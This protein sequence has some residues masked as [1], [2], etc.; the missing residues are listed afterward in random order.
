[1]PTH[2]VYKILHR[3]IRG[4]HEAAYLLAFFTLGSQLMALVRDRLLAHKFG[5]G[6]VLDVFY[7]AFRIPDTMYAILASMVS[8]FVLIPFLERARRD[9]TDAIQRFLSDMFSFFSGALVLF[10]LIVFV[11]TPELIAVLYGGFSASMQADLVP[12]VRI[13]L[14]Q[15][16]LLGISNLFAAYVQVQG[17]FLLYA[18][19]PIVYNLGIIAG[20]VFLEP[21]IGIQGLAWGVVFGALLHLLIQAPFVAHQGVFP[22]LVWPEW[23]RVYDVVR[24]SIP[25]TLTLSAQQLVILVL[26]SIAALF[27]VGSVSSFSLA[28]NLQ[29]VPLAIIGA[30]YSVAAFPKLA[31]LFGNGDHVEYRALILTAARQILFWAFPATILVIILRAQLVRVIFGTGA[32]D[33]DD[34][35]LVGAMLALL[36]VSLVAQSLVVLLVRACYAAGQTTVPLI[37][38]LT[39]SVLTVGLAFLFLYLAQANIINTHALAT[40]M[41]VEGV[42]GNEVLLVAVAYSLGS[43]VN[44]LLLLWYFERTF[45]QIFRGLFTTVWQSLAASLIGGLAAYGALNIFDELVS[46]Q[47]AQGVFLQ[48]AAAGLI[49]ITAWVLALI[50]VGSSDVAAAWDALRRKITR[51][52]IDEARGDVSSGSVN[53]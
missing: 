9:G 14:L 29:A 39:S 26:V 10:A 8:L 21:T 46:L 53:V 20:I 31:R 17:R 50:T 12:M 5:A 22:K 42:P 2:T 44:A 30:S 38:N 15:P 28:W 3:E 1:M 40:L 43:I 19:A 41:R 52:R 33:W 34:T 13:L 24:V 35:M 4:L 25:R 32:F 27:A 48:G 7:A 23:G 45:H 36:V 16:L 18:L 51:R 11:F 6:E 49:G 37:L 47:T